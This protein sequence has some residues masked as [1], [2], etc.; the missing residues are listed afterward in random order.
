MVLGPRPL[1]AW[2]WCVAGASA[3]APRPPSARLLTRRSGLFDGLKNPFDD[4]PG[5][6]VSKVQVALYNEGG[7]DSASG[8]LSD[9]ARKLEEDERDSALAYFVADVSTGL[10]RR[11]ASWAYA[12]CETRLFDGGEVENND[13]ER[14]FNKLVNSEEAK[15]EKEYVPSAEEMEKIAAARGGM[16]VV[17]LITAIEGD[18]MWVFDGASTSA[19]GL[20]ET[21]RNLGAQALVAG[22][23][24][25]YNG[26]VLWTP[27]EPGEALFKDD[28]LLDF[29]ELM[30]L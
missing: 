7:R 5:C 2:A 10:S 15:Y 24:E 21:L 23:D 26:E 9:A 6:T 4:R 25:L 14:Y 3:M 29:P 28:M 19:R 8:F 1:F 20:G 30:I 12:S 11:K 18:C 27:S 16:C 22:G 17:S 13:H